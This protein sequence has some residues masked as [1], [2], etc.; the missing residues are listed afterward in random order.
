M[1]Q[2]VLMNPKILK[3]KQFLKLFSMLFEIF[4]SFQKKK[5]NLCVFPI[6]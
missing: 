4:V 5:L 3:E 6:S 2:Y 1:F